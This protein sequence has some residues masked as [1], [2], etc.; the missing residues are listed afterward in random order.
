[1]LRKGIYLSFLTAIISGF[2]IFA[3]K[4]FV[5]QADPLAFTTIRNVMVGIFLTVV[6]ISS[7]KNKSLRLLNIK[8]IIKLAV[9]GI[10]G[11]GLAFA[12]F[13]TGL[14]KIGS[15][16][17]NLIHKTL[18]IWVAIL[19]IP[20]LKERL[21]RL[22]MAGYLVIFATMFIVG[23]PVTFNFNNGSLLV[24]AATILWAIENVVAKATLR[25]VSSE[26]VGWA[27][28]II[29]I[30]VLFLLTIVLGKGQLLF[31][32][33]TLSIMPLFTS[34]LFLTFYIL[35]WYKALS[36]APAT[37]VTSILVIAP[38]L[39]N[40]L[41]S[42][43]ITHDF[44]QLQTNT[45]IFLIIGVGLIVVKILRPIYFAKKLFIK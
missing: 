8:D 7:G 32:P 17:G 40:L 37:L 22:Q 44:P 20:L 34:S 26:I 28:I 19:A 39:T 5:S 11:G 27:R 35:T 42:V 38:A 33:K 3:N 10:F 13:F 36:Y 24:L 6:L 29:G 30:P 45:A 31:I 15:L 4:I 1:M 9:I 23:G 12:L 18:F 41:T 43:F 2:S 14:A 21:N 16:Q 25:N